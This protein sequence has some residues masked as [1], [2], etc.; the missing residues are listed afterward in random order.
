MISA[1]YVHSDSQPIQIVELEPIKTFGGIDVPAEAIL[2]SPSDIAISKEGEIIVSDA[3]E[4]KLFVFDSDGRLIRTIGREG[5]GPGELNGPRLIGVEDGV[6]KVFEARNNR[7]QYF[8]LKGEHLKMMPLG[9][10]IGT[11]T[12]V[13][14]YKDDF[15]YATQGFRTEDLINHFQV[16]GQK[17]DPIGKIEGKPF[18]FYEMLQIQEALIKKEIPD[19][20]RNEVLLIVTA[21]G[22]LFAFFQALPLVRIYSVDGKLESTITL[23]MPEFEEVKTRC[24]QFN[25]DLKKKGMP[26]FMG[27][28][29]WRDG[30]LMENGDVILLLADPEKMNLFRFDKD[31][32]LTKRYHGVKD[33]ILMLA[34]HGSFLWAYGRETQVFYQFKIGQ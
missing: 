24:I 6:I 28:K 19:A 34:S 29:F 7:F 11:G 27:L 23:N 15:F 5:T 10:S 30:V 1:F 12:L 21:G 33:D 16:S 2:N 22:R 31:G 3:R 32:K 25:V 14:G 4:N 17:L 20:C 8:T 9:F 13:L 18:E 26:G